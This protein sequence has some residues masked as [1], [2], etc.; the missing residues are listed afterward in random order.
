M[1]FMMGIRLA[2]AGAAF[3]IAHETTKATKE[4]LRQWVADKFAS[5]S[6]DPAPQPPNSCDAGRTAVN[7]GGD[8]VNGGTP[9]DIQ[10]PTLSPVVVTE[11]AVNGERPAHLEEPTVTAVNVTEN[12]VEGDLTVELEQSQPNQDN[13]INV[14]VSRDF[15][16][17][18]DAQSN[19]VNGDVTV[20]LP[21]RHGVNPTREAPVVVVVDAVS[22]EATGVHRT[23]DD[24]DNAIRV[25]KT[26]AMDESRQT[27]MD[28]LAQ[29]VPE[30]APPPDQGTRRSFMAAA[31]NAVKGWARS[32]FNW[33]TAIKVY[34]LGPERDKIRRILVNVGFRVMESVI[35][36]PL[37]GRHKVVRKIYNILKNEFWNSW[38]W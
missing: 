24:V 1:A 38:C 28:E 34:V 9:A 36:D 16:S 7:E 33:P 3:I 35:L 31:V 26:R 17:H 20:E 25:D 6:S 8:F 29:D 15:P 14:P 27:D 2:V 30:P 21:Q 22:L 18:L 5:R 37:L 10:E 13:A 12:V 23:V 4:K 19:A 11:N 32:L